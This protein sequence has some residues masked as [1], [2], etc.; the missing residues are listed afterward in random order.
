MKESQV[1]RTNIRF[2]DLSYQN[3]RYQSIFLLSKHPIFRVPP[4]LVEGVN[5]WYRDHR[6]VPLSRFTQ[7]TYRNPTLEIEEKSLRISCTISKSKEVSS[8]ERPQ[9]IRVW[10]LVYR[11]DRDEVTGPSLTLGLN[12]KVKMIHYTNSLY[13]H[14]E[15]ETILLVVSGVW[16]YTSS[17][18]LTWPCT[19]Q[20]IKRIQ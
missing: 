17:D 14:W 15:P 12:T 3:I 19:P 20:G 6:S 10:T 1:E 8:R 18:H 7:L 9:R 16:G 5:Q 11:V 4:I 13:V 2:L